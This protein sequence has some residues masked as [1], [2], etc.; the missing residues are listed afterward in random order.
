MT[1]LN[2]ILLTVALQWGVAATVF[3]LLALAAVH[4]FCGKSAQ[5]RHHL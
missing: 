2:R 3:P 5:F 1:T 4:V